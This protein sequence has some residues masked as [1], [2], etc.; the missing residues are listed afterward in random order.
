[1]QETKENIMKRKANL[2]P[3][4]MFILG[5][6]IVAA[7]LLNSEASAAEK[8]TQNQILSNFT[9][10]GYAK[11]DGEYYYINYRNNDPSKEPK[12]ILVKAKVDGFFF[13]GGTCIPQ[14]PV[15]VEYTWQ[16]GINGKVEKISL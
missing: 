3:A 14:S 13:N 16:R 2:I 8:M 6:V 4:L 10:N 9:S 11:A 7:L 15:F 5:F 1:M 12:Y